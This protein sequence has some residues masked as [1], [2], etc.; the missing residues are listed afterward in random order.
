M[1]L[2]I[3][4]ALFPLVIGF[5]YDARQPVAV[6]ADD[7]DGVADGE[8]VTLDKMQAKKLKR[9]RWWLL[10]VAALPMFVLVALRGPHMGADTG[11]YLKFFDQMVN[12]PWDQIFVRNEATYE[13]EEGF[14]IFEKLLTYVTD[15]SRVYQVLYTLVYLLALVT[16]ANELE[17]G[18]FA[19]LFFFAT[20]GTYTFMFTGVRQCLAMSICLLSYPFIKRKKLIP[21]ILLVI[22][23]FF[24]HKS[25]I[26]FLAAYFIYNRR[27][28]WFN[29]VIYGVLAAL[30]FIN[31]ETIQE[32]FNDTL[33]YEYGIEATDT[34]FIFFAI[35]VLVTA[36]AYFAILHYKKET[37]ESVGLLNVAGITLVLWLLRLETR[38]AE[39]PSYYFMFFSAAVLCHALDAPTKNGDKLIYKLVVY[40]AFLVLFIYRFMTNFSS[41]VPYVSFF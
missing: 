1:F 20:M 30:A 19:F 4:V 22:L 29:A 31:I 7:A 35:I 14:V 41:L 34:G 38:V 28:G 33:D 32:W 5:F 11:G 39:R 2:Y 18:R 26:L 15:D 10:L 37:R 6:A 23:A 40:A 36:F 17:K 13:F 12:T 16:F 21:F 24:F 3:L 27:L 25:A 9:R 8:A